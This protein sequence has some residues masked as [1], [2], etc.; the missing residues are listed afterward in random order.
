MPSNVIDNFNHAL[1]QEELENDEGRR[2]R[3]YADKLGLITIGIG[4]NL[5]GRGISDAEIDFLF[6]NDVQACCDIMDK[7]IPWWR[8]LPPTKQR[9]M[10]N[11]CFMGWGSFSQ[12][13][14]FMSYM[15]VGRWIDASK[16]LENS[17]WFQ[18]VR[19]RG[20]RVVQRLLT[21]EPPG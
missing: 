21:S 8:T 14:K 1:L 7:E 3:P 10:I 5:T 4:R 18:Q 19:L 2:G 6:Q 13:H 11:L 9:V 15:Q 12:F 17:K 20:P 16:E